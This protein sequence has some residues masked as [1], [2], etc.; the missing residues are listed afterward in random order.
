MLWLGLIIVYHVIKVSAQYTV[1]SFAGADTRVCE[2]PTIITNPQCTSV[3]PCKQNIM[4]ITFL[5]CRT[6]VE[7]VGPT[8]YRCYTN[9]ICLLD[10]TGILSLGL[11][12]TPHGYYFILHLFNP[13]T[14][15]VS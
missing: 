8:L 1:T 6:N 14:H 4:C 2:T 10:T 3:V 11:P 13:K 12:K 15:R 9:V 5:Q 7:D